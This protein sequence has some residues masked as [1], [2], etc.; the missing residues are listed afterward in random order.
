MK[1]LNL[2][3]ESKRQLLAAIRNTKS[4][5]KKVACFRST[6]VYSYP[7]KENKKMAALLNAQNCP[8]LTSDHSNVTWWCRN[9]EQAITIICCVRGRS[10]SIL[11]GMVISSCL[12]CRRLRVRIHVIIFILF[13]SL[14]IPQRTIIIYSDFIKYYKYYFYSSIFPFL[15]TD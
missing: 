5:K 6:L 13:I 9:I 1:F 2:S 8:S 3:C 7:L 15:D 12:E 10:V 11:C 4:K 14:F